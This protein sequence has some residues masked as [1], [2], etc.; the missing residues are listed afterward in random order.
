[1]NIDR[2]DIMMSLLNSVKPEICDCG[3]AL[4]D[5]GWNETEVLSP[6][7]RL[8][9]ICDGEGILS[10]NNKQVIMTPGNLYF[11][12][13]R[14]NFSYRCES[15]LEKLYF[16]INVPLPEKYDL[17]SDCHEIISIPAKDT[18]EMIGQY[19]SSTVFES[20]YLNSR[21]QSDVIKLIRAS[22]LD[23]INILSYS[24]TVHRAIGYINDNLSVKLNIKDIADSLFVSESKLSKLFR[25][26]MGISIG[27]YIDDK[28]IFEIEKLLADVAYPINDISD[29]F[30]FCDRFYFSRRFK[31]K[32]G[33]TPRSY[34][35]RIKNIYTDFNKK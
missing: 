4:C 1:M 10:Y 16:H 7:S 18:R 19:K 29:K 32:T 33:E 9:Y 34:R 8:Y 5:T 28:I 13:L 12:P 14:L 6:F 2:N 3:Y 20:L 11:V 31:E 22:G 15:Y 24:E 21:I 26:E 25:T 27:K 30:G 23:N 35:T 17:F